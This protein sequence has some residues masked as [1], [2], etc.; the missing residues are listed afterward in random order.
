MRF[1]Y[2]EVEFT[3]DGSFHDTA[4]LEPRRD[5]SARPVSPTSS[6]WRTAG[7]TTW[8]RPAACSAT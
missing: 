8:G 7:T 2:A 6:C 5:S 3:T 4:Q 1:P